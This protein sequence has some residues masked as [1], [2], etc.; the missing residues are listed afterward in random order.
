M[1][2]LIIAGVENEVDSTGVSKTPND[3]PYKF[4]LKL[5]RETLKKSTDMR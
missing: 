4:V 2:Q 3:I 1:A 5:I